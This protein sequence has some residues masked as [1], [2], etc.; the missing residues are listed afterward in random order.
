[1]KKRITI[2]DIARELNTTISTVS[3]ALRDHPRISPEM[4]ERVKKYAKEHDYQ[5]DF[6]ASSL[7]MGSG[8]T[9]GVLVPRIDIHF[10]AKVLRGIDEIASN[11]NYNVLICQS[12]DSLAKEENIIRSLLYG[13]VD[14]LIASISVETKNGDHFGVLQKKGL[15]VVLFDKIIEDM[16]VN[17]VIIDDH[18]GAYISVL[19]LIKNGFKRIGLFGG[20]DYLN[21]YK[22]REAGY[23]D[24]LKDHGFEID[25]TIIF[26]EMLTQEKGYEAMEKLMQLENPPDAIFSVNDFAIIGAIIRAKEMGLKVPNDIAFTGFANEPMDA[27]FEP[28]ISS[29]EQYPVKMGQ[30]SV[31]L[32]IEQME[33]KG[34][35]SPPRTIVIKPSLIVRK[36]SMRISR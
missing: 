23:Y 13:K 15:P 19:H 12:F 6:R 25:D 28:S 24:A 22:Q 4:R 30:E 33:S 17:K 34:K 11:E 31:K 2:Q 1:M 16:E 21:I 26:K 29:I 18:Y 35:D 27:I 9:I 3:R 10:F 36:S 7:R 5:P 32:L 20:F 8:R 14:G